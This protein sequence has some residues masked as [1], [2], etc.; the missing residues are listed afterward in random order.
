VVAKDP[1]PSGQVSKA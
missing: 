1:E